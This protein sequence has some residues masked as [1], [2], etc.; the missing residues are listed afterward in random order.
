MAFKYGRCFDF[1]KEGTR[2]WPTITPSKRFSF[3]I[4]AVKIY[5]GFEPL[6][7]QT[8]DYYIDICCFFAKHSTVRN[9]N[10]E[11]M[12]MF[13]SEATCLLMECCFNESGTNVYKNP[14]I[15]PV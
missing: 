13:L 12:V 1:Y 6:S 3:N 5:R 9:R 8:K 2:W 7:G 10:K 11:I 4:G 15:S 14:A